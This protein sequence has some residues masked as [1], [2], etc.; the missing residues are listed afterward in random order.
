MFSKLRR[1]HLHCTNKSEN[2]STSVKVEFEVDRK[3]LIALLKFYRQSEYYLFEYD[4]G[5]A[6]VPL[7]KCSRILT[8]DK[9]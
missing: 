2:E 3:N 8:S 5:C 9:R 7:H 1:L 6:E 4:T